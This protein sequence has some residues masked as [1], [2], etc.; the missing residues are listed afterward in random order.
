MAHLRT[1]GTFYA[2]GIETDSVNESKIPRGQIKALLS[3][4]KSVEKLAKKFSA[5]LKVAIGDK[6]MQKVVADN[7]KEKEDSG[8][9]HSGDYCDSNMV[10]DD[11]FKSALK[12][13]LSNDWPYFPGRGLDKPNSDEGLLIQLWN[14]AWNLA[15]KNHFYYKK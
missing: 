14:K 15:K 3:D 12:L 5:L 10:M 2:P 13:D 8:I 4:E 1:F 11:A 9:C 7:S 6:K